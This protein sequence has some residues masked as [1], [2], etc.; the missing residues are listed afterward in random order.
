MKTLPG[1]AVRPRSR[2]Q[3][4]VAAGFVTVAPAAI[5]IDALPARLASE[6]HPPFGRR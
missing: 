1:Q 2:W 4:Y 3:A 6:A 5:E